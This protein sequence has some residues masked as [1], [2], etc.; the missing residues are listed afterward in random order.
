LPAGRVFQAGT[1]SGNPLATAAGCAT[2]LTLRDDPPYERLETLSAR[3]EVGLRNAAIA[4]GVAHQFA[5]VGSMMTLF[6]ADEPIS[7]WTTA[8]RCDTKRFAKYFWGMLDRGIYLPC[9]QY[10]ALFVSA[11][12]S[13]ADVDAT[14]EAAREALTIL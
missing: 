9:S 11:A 2:L 4:A 14:I 1:L 6:F 13:E 12:H 8:S 5:R 10:E 7:D 3:L